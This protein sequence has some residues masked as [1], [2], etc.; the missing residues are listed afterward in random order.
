MA[1]GSSGGGLKMFTVDGKKILQDVKVERIATLSDGRYIIRGRQSRNT[2]L[3]LYTK[4]W[5]KESVAFHTPYVN[6]GNYIGG[7]CV[8]N[9]DNI[10]VGN[11]RDMKIAVFRPQGGA[12]IKQKTSPGLRPWYIRH[13]NHSNLLV[14]TDL[15]TVRVID[16]E[17]TVK[18]DVSKDGYG[19]RCAL[20]QDDSILIAWQKDNLLTI[21][22]Y[23]PQLK[24]VRMVLS[25]FKIEGNNCCLAEFSTGEIAFPDRNNLYVFH[26]T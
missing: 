22:L 19:A 21:D 25:K 1:V 10:Y 17:G 4:D 23:T 7:M 2:T 16:E 26:K 12:A 13:M 18:H 3:T 14:V 9:H 24:Y 15:Y 20:L 5:K 6:Y 11:F 8:D